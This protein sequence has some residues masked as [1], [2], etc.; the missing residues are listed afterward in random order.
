MLITKLCEC[1]AGFVV[2]CI[3]S[4]GDVL[5]VLEEVALL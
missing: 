1:L 5:F 2:A 4:I 3:D